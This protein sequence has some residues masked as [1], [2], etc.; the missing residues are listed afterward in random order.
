MLNLRRK[1]IGVRV[2]LERVVKT[3][4]KHN[5]A[6]LIAGIDLTDSDI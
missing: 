5:I 1:Q 6:S 4:P 3:F 2:T